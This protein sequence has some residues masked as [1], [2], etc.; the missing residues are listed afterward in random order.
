[1]L[2]IKTTKKAANMLEQYE[3]GQAR[4]EIDTFF[5]RDFCDYYIEIAKERLYQPEKHGV[6]NRYSGQVALYHCLLGILKMIVL[7]QK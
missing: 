6:E 7:L 5:W 2:I 1:M 4:H 3:I